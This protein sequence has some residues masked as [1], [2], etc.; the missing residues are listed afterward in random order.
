[1]KFNKLLPPAYR[2]QLLSLGGSAGLTF[3]TAFFLPPSERGTLAIFLTISAIGG[4]LICLGT[5]SKILQLN[6]TG[7][8]FRSSII[9]QGQIPIQ[10]FLSL[11]LYFL[12]SSTEAFPTF[13]LYT[14]VA[15][16]LS[17]FIGGIFNNFSWA[18]YG[19]NN[20]VLSTA[21]RGLIPLGTLLVTLVHGA[22]QEYDVRVAIGTYVC[23]QTIS[24]FAI[25]TKLPLRAPWRFSIREVLRTY[26]QTFSYFLTQG[27]TQ[28]LA[29]SPVLA[30]GLWL[31]ASNTAVVAI[32]LSI[33]EL[34]SSLP[35]MR[36]AMTFQEASESGQR[37]LTV[38]FLRKAVIALLP[39]TLIVVAISFVATMLLPSEYRN[40]PL[41][42]AI[43]S[44][45]IAIQAIAASAINIMTLR[46][47]LGRSIIIIVACIVGAF[48]SVYFG[49]VL[50]L[51]PSLLIWT[52]IVG[53][54]GSILILL[55][56]RMPRR[57]AEY[58]VEA[59]R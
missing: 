18:Q 26:R 5:Q 31:G 24:L 3:I 57:S 12:L 49:S 19:R 46:Q 44:F 8:E 27:L 36:S 30:A 53:V 40:L 47:E 29:R 37:H 34:Q 11:S 7:R 25:A 42:V 48:A 54:A 28:I 32:A 6:A 50:G 38:A 35:Q 51:I 10:L 41:I 4:Y 59:L 2:A 17:V 1:M 16:C 43:F 9:I 45:G 14:I 21:M 55:A 33:S 39:G 58:P 20:F 13:D 52:I 22:L 56:V 23:L 15:V